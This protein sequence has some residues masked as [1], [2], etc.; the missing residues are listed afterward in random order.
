VVAV[1]VGYFHVVALPGSYAPRYHREEEIWIQ[2]GVPTPVDRAGQRADKQ[3]QHERYQ[4]SEDRVP[5][6]RDAVQ[7]EVR[8]VAGTPEKQGS[9]ISYNIDDERLVNACDIHTVKRLA[10][11][12]DELISH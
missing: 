11:L 10:V 5:H 2:I 9:M 6:V 3:T 8:A 1:H 7:I 12:L 4:K